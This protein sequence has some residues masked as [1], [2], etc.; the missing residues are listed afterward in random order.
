[1]AEMLN[2]GRFRRP[3][4]KRR[5]QAQEDTMRKYY[6]MRASYLTSTCA[7]HATVAWGPPHVEN[8]EYGV[9]ACF[10]GRGPL[11]RRKRNE[12]TLRSTSTLYGMQPCVRRTGLGSYIVGWGGS[13]LY[14]TWY[15][16]GR[17][18][19]AGRFPISEYEQTQEHLLHTTSKIRLRAGPF[20]FF[21]HRPLD[22]PLASPP[23]R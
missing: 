17:G 15:P 2:I 11:A 4:Q 20:C 9:C 14:L 10:L 21:G 1:M 16:G 19:P 6:T 7:D 13:L 3:T 8:C 12:K 5:K 18:S 22:I 23:V